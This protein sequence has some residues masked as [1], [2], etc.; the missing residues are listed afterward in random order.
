MSSGRG[1]QR[2]RK[3]KH[4][5]LIN[6]LAHGRKMYESTP[7]SHHGHTARKGWG[8]GGRWLAE[9]QTTHSTAVLPTTCTHVLLWHANVCISALI[10]RIAFCFERV[11]SHSRCCGIDSSAE[12]SGLGVSEPTCAGN[13]LPRDWSRL[14]GSGFQNR[15]E[16]STRRSLPSLV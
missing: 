3:S 15:V 4:K 10:D 8:G 12:E 7:W 11:G 16:P 5:N 6:Q 1:R 9:L 14:L 13:R 2:D